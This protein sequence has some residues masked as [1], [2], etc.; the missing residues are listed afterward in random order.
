MHC[1]IHLVLHTLRAAELQDEA[2]AFRPARPGLRHRVGW[3][4]IELG[5]RLTQ[6]PPAPA[7]TVRAV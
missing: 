3:T 1:D 2:A 6:A 7:R 5:L 4:M